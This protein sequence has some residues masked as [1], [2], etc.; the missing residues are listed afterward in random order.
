MGLCLARP[1][2]VDSWRGPLPRRRVSPLPILGFFL[3]EALAAHAS[4]SSGAA[5]SSTSTT[6][7]PEPAAA[8]AAGI[9]NEGGIEVGSSVRTLLHADLGPSWGVG[10]VDVPVG[11]AHLR[12]RRRRVHR[13]PYGRAYLPVTSSSSP[14]SRTSPSPS[15][16]TAPASRSSPRAP[17]SPS[18]ATPGVPP[19][20][21]R[22]ASASPWSQG[23]RSYLNVASRLPM[24]CFARWMHDGGS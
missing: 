9:A 6:T 1:L 20:P 10:G 22:T 11:R 15:S 4:A 17:S 3:G 16:P 24:A 13:K 23:C 18:T 7:T 8:T 19:L 2:R 21:P 14:A 12:R 5:S